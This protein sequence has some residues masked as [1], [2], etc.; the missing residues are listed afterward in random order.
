MAWDPEVMIRE[1]PDLYN[2]M[3]RVYPHVQTAIHA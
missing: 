2:E 3:I 1:H